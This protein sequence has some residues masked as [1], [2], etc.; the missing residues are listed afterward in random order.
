MTN[1]HLAAPPAARETA[2]VARLADV[3]LRYGKA[4]AL[5]AVTLAVPAG[6]MVGMIGPD[7]VGK[8]SLLALI[9]GARAMKG[10]RVEVLG[11]DMGEARHR[12][13]V[14]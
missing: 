1:G 2:P 14:C 12:R 13:D 9:A 3:S 5:D 7:G 8:S 11:G 10:G 6:H 4:R